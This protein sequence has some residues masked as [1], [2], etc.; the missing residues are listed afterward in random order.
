MT[1]GQETTLRVPNILFR[2]KHMPSKKISFLPPESLKATFTVGALSETT[3]WGLLATGV[4][5]AHKHT[6]G[7]GVTVAVL[8]TGGPNHIDVNG[9]L[10]AAINC[11]GTGTPDDNQGHGTHVAGIIAALENGIGVV[12]VAPEAKILPIKVLDDSGRSGFAQIAQ[13]I[14]AAIQA[15]VDIINMSLG[16]PSTPPD[17]FYTAVQEAH[18]AG[19][20]MVAAAGNDA[21]A[22]NWPARY[23]EVIAVSAIDNQGS[24]ANFS[25]HGDQVDFG[26]PGVN[27][28]STYLNNQYAVLNGTS[29]A[30]PFIAGV[31]ALLLAWTRAH[32]D[33]PQI[34]NSEDMLKALSKFTDSAGRLTD[35]QFGFGIPKFINAELEDDQPAPVPE[36]APVKPPTVTPV[37]PVNNNTTEPF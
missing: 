2:E 29:Q 8:D 12:G 37:A 10:L 23:D 31:C 25:S 11:S 19:I 28:Y 22:V 17:D 32:P 34:K 7:A 9:N 26:A 13:G 27:I 4:P 20:I 16:A 24:L 36:P 18:A 1:F 5:D 15:K 35:G 33:L 30:A 14:R 3:D 21:G 6:R